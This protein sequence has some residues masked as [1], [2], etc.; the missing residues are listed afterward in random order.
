MNE[1][2]HDLAALLLAGLLNFLQLHLGF[3]VC[4]FLGLLV[5]TRVLEGQFCQFRTKHDCGVGA[6]LGL[7]LLKLLLLLRSVFF[8]FLL[9]L[10]LGVS[11]SLRPVCRQRLGSV[12]ARVE[13]NHTFSSYRRS[14]S[15]YADRD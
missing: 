7:E 9:R 1:V 15:V 10:R 2:V 5:S 13:G 12:S 8:D 4:V 14:M 6:H 3:L 11:Y